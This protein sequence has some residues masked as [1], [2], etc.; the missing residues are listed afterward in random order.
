MRRFVRYLALEN[1]TLLPLP[2]IVRRVNQPSID[3]ED[4]HV[5]MASML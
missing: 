3:L 5:S 4:M 1:P 2:I